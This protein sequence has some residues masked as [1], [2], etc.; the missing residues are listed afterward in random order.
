MNTGDP[1]RQPRQQDFDLLREYDLFAKK[2]WTK[3]SAPYA[4]PTRAIAASSTC[5]RSGK[6]SWTGFTSRTRWIV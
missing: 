5:S 2:L 6:P 4:M 3:S 1:G